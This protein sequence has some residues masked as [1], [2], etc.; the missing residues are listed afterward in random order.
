MSR[1]FEHRVCGEEL[2]EEKLAR[3]VLGITDQAGI[4]VGVPRL[5]AARIVSST[6]LAVAF[7][8]AVV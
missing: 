2:V 1:C 3:C 5:D 4:R 6:G 8:F 7:T